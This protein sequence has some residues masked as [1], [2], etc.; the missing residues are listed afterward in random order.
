V[1]KLAARFERGSAAPWVPDYDPRMLAGIVG[2]E[3][4]IAEIQGKFKVSQNRTAEDRAR[5]AARLEARGGDE[6]TALAKLVA[7]ERSFS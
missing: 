1:E 5:V 4:A 6:S 7:G 2:L 3:I